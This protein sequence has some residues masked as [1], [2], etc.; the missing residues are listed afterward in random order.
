MQW[1]KEELRAHLIERTE[2]LYWTL[3][4]AGSIKKNAQIAATECFNAIWKNMGKKVLP[5]VKL[6][7]LKAS[8]RT[9]PNWCKERRY[10]IDLDRVY[11]MADYDFPVDNLLCLCRS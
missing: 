3:V 6:V 10:R 9:K 2:R 11:F 7:D 8:A 5:R 1:T 4:R